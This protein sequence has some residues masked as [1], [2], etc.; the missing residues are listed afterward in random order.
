[1]PNPALWRGEAAPPL[2]NSLLAR[3]LQ[4][5]GV[6]AIVLAYF[7]QWHIASWVMGDLRWTMAVQVCE[8][9][10]KNPPVDKDITLCG[11]CI[12][13]GDYRI[14]DDCSNEWTPGDQ[15][16][17]WKVI[18]GHATRDGEEYTTIQTFCPKC[19]DAN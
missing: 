16:E 7:E 8:G 10:G 1:M 9:C 3:N 15:L 18:L 19:K 11:D 17:G 2:F 4:A 6:D 12:D 14:C 5:Q 13:S